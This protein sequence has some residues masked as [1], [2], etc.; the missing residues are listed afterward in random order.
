[1]TEPSTQDRVYNEN[2][3]DVSIVNPAIIKVRRLNN[4][5]SNIH[6]H[7]LGIKSIFTD[8][9]QLMKIAE[10]WR[11]LLRLRLITNSQENPDSK[12]LRLFG[13]IDMIRKYDPRLAGII[14]DYYKNRKEV[15]TLLRELFSD[16]PSRQG[17]LRI[18]SNFDIIEE[19]TEKIKDKVLK[20]RLLQGL[21]LLKKIF[22]EMSFLEDAALQ[23]A[24]KKELETLIRT[25]TRGITS[26]TWEGFYGP[27]SLAESEYYIELFESKYHNKSIANSLRANKEKYSASYPEKWLG[28]PLYPDELPNSLWSIYHNFESK[29]LAR[30]DQLMATALRIA[31]ITKRVIEQEYE[32]FPVIALTNV[33]KR[34]Y[35]FEVHVKRLWNR[36]R[37]KFQDLFINL[38]MTLEIMWNNVKKIE[39]YDESY[40]KSKLIATAIQHN[41]SYSQLADKVI[42]SADSFKKPALEHMTWLALITRVFSYNKELQNKA[43]YSLEN[44][45]EIEKK[46]L[47][48]FNAS[49]NSV[50]YG[51]NQLLEYVK[52]LGLIMATPQPNI[53]ITQLGELNG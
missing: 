50:I 37:K 42:L 22:E 29:R 39:K 44:P 49:F 5:V 51:Y 13:I 23:S 45:K 47:D 28:N 31:E 24:T 18:R 19:R 17:I 1:M 4:L 34:V 2:S 41:I 14:Q 38:I 40:D 43:W 7:V 46:L 26:Q 16:I 33:K 25:I 15:D 35:H 8:N 30:F 21:L 48:D 52:S 12:L 9:R 10:D 32:K 3:S 27:N 36:R 20:Y 6:D 11:L 53:R